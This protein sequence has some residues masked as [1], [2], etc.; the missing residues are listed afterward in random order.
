MHMKYGEKGQITVKQT[1]QQFVLQN[2]VI[3]VFSRTNCVKYEI[4]VI[5]TI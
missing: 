3:L 1:Q 4:R 2:I 5:K